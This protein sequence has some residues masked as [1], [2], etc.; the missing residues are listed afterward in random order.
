LKPFDSNGEF[1]SPVEGV[2]RLAIRGAGLTVFSSGIGLA[3]QIVATVVLARL[4]TPGD[5]GLVTMVTTFSLLF[6]NFGLNGFTESI[7]QREKINHGLASNLFWINLG[8]GL[9]LTGAF[10]GAGSLLAHFYHNPLV[11]N[12]A[13]GVSLSII[14]T[15]A[16]VLH[17]ALLKRDLQ[18]SSVSINDIVAAVVSV[19]VSIGL[20]WAG[21]GYWALVAGVVARPVSVSI[22][23]WYLCRWVPGWP[24]RVEGTG[25]AVGFAAHVYGRFTVNYFARNIDNLLVGWRFG[26][27]SLGFYK[28]AYDLFAL[29]AGQLTSPLTN[30]AV[31]AMSR[32]NPRS[33]Q[34]RQHLLSA[35]SVLAFIGMGLSA[36]LTLVGKSLIRLLLGPGWETAGRIFTF[37]GPGIGVMLLYQVNGWIHLSI[38]KASRWLRWGLVEV[39]VTCL[40]FLLALRWGPE[41]IAG[42]WTASFWILTLPALWYAGAPIGLG[43]SPVIGAIWRF[44]AASILAVSA[45]AGIIWRDP[46]LLGNS[47]ST[48]ELLAGIARVSILFGVLYLSAVMVLHR[49]WG[50]VHQLMGLLRE[51]LAR[52]NALTSAESVPHYRPVT[53]AGRSEYL[54][55]ILVPA[56]NAE[57]SIAD[58]L[59]SALAQTW[60]RKEIIVVDDGS[61]D[62]TVA[63]AEQFQAE[64]VRVVQQKNQGASAARNLAFSLS[65]GDYIQWL[66]ADDILAPDKIAQ[67]L[68]TVRDRGDERLLLS[69]AWGRFI[70]RYYRAEFVPTALWCDLNPLEWLLRKMGQNLYMQ[71]AS[72]LV[73]RELTQAA[74]PWDTRLLSDDDG[75]YFCRVLLASDGVRFVP[76]AKVYYRG[77]GL[78]FRSLSYIGQSDRKLDAHWLSMRLHID[79]L[80]SLEDSHRAREASIR[81]LQ[82]SLLFFYPEKVDI[83]KEAAHLARDLGGQLGTPSLSWKYSWIKAIFGWHVGKIGQEI[84]LRS[85]WSIEK[86]WD[87]AM[88]NLENL[89]RIE[90]ALTK[91]NCSSRPSLLTSS[92]RTEAAEASVA[93]SH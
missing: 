8:L 20:A 59:R 9:L 57:E 39:G 7:L 87:L 42:A 29:S 28:K 53:Q 11:T 17:L 24:R 89:G 60:E 44:L 78:A 86:I 47:A 81:Y 67:Q 73:S 25:S 69:S 26:A 88:F 30:V 77:P 19:V 35:L 54:V 51:I 15:S 79:Y 18:F 12:V 31:S 40:L 33:A 83:V 5:F 75:E 22:G 48:A 43:I 52:D 46:S 13:V 16:S 70:Y 41:G 90:H 61:S 72:W 23:A 21:W 63:I 80:R 84:L 66:D 49:G 27:L 4:L 10:A 6:V 2:T 58:T 37:F 64:G 56:F 36:E 32:L 38:G 50:P 93:S 65:R 71:T 82:T 3:I 92:P 68:E 55:S 62:R 85:R 1:Q 14:A 34:Y 76:D 91:I 74:G 45:V